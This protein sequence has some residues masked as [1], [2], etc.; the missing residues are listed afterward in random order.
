MNRRR[1]FTLIELMVVVIVLS[2]LAGIAVLKYI[3]LR[4]SAIAAQMSQELRAVQVAALNYYADKEEW[5]AEAGAG[6]VPVGLAPLL[7]GQL[8]GSFDREQYV[9][10]YENF[11]EEAPDIVIGVSVTTSD[12][13]LFAKFT[14]YLGTQ[15]PFFLSGSK[16][17]YLITGPGGTF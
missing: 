6:A 4:N 16:L 15:S 2:L 9:L 14:Q 13:R 17:T 11:G 1:G 8:S 5:P 7:P 10:D 12:T 3:D